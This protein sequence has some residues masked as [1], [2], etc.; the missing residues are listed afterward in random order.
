MERGSSKNVSEGDRRVNVKPII[1]PDEI[2]LTD[3]FLPDI[4]LSD[5][6]FTIE[7]E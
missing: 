1:P 2:T 7:D 5:L 6:I 3:D 4:D